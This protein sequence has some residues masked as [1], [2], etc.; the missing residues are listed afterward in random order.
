MSTSPGF[1]LK[2]EQF[3]RPKSYLWQLRRALR[4]L[5]PSP[6][7][8]RY[9]GCVRQ[10]YKAAVQLDIYVTVR[11]QKDGSYLVWKLPPP[12]AQ[13]Q[14]PQPPLVQPQIAQVRP[15]PTGNAKP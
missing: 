12:P 13:A 15:M 1:S 11:R 9:R 7:C 3:E 8:L 5:G 4:E 2:L 10:V 14:P 6:A